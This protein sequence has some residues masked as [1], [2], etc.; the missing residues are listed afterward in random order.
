MAAALVDNHSRNTV[1]KKIPPFGGIFSTQP[2][3]TDHARSLMAAFLAL[4][5]LL[6]RLVAR[7]LLLLTGLLA[8]ALL[9]RLLVWILALLAGF[10]VRIVLV[11]HVGIS[12][13]ERK[14]NRRRRR[15]L[16]WNSR[17][18][19]ELFIAPQTGVDDDRTSHPSAVAAPGSRC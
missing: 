4:L 18:L 10:L 7:I 2:L 14:S 9:T 11:A 13:V 19:H 12:F 6:A 8:T 17:F 15:W 1:Q 5:T 16:Q 3:R